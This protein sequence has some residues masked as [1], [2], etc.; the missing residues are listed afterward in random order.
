VSGPPPLRSL[1]LVLH[2]DGRFL[3]EGAPVTNRRLRAAFDRG[4]RW[5]PAEGKY[6]VTLGHFR[7]QVD[8]E[9]AGFFVRSLDLARGTIALSD[10]TEEALDAASLRASALD[11]DVL[12]CTVKRALT[13]YGVPARFERGAQAELLAALE[14]GEDGGWVLPIVGRR[15]ALSRL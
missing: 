4:V 3:H 11:P 1:G 14:Q 8:V 15:V 10:R 2:R 7:G 5:L 12:L 9:E 13:P 6:V